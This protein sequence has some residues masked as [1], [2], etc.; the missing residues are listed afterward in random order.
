[1][2]HP[3]VV[4]VMSPIETWKATRRFP[5]SNVVTET[6]IFHRKVKDFCPDVE[7]PC[8]DLACQLIN[9]HSY[10]N[11]I[12]GGGQR[13]FYPNN[14]TL[15]SDGTSNGV[16]LDKRYLVNEWNATHENDMHCYVG[17]PSDLEK[18]D[19]STD[20]YILGNKTCQIHSYLTV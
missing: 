8:Q 15:P 11:V 5:N 3:V 16:R 6:L 2:L 19:G 18:C 7:M 20:D 17:K 4:M 9:D 10:I 13:N 1:M 12:M 14:E